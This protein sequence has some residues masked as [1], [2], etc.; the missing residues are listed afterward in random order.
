MKRRSANSRFVHAR[1]MACALMA[2]VAV[3]AADSV[4]PPP[5]SGERR[6]AAA[7]PE[8][9][10][11]LP[12]V[13]VTGYNLEPGVPVVPLDAIGSRLNL[14]VRLEWL[15]NVEG[16]D[17]VAGWKFDETLSAALPGGGASYKLTEHWA[18][19]GNYFLGFGAPQT[20]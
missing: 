9:P 20:F 10:I 19:F 17:R 14:G 16:C 13:M 6:A 11:L 2:A 4:P 1:W 5:G 15:P 7:E 3:Q 18:V 12:P 8:P